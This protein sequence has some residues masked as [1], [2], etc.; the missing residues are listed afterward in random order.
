M[1]CPNC[2][3]RTNNC[4]Y[5]NLFISDETAEWYCKM[6][7]YSLQGC[8]CDKR[9]DRCQR[10]GDHCVCRNIKE[11]TKILEELN[12]RNE[13][14]KLM[15]YKA[16]VLEK[17]ETAIPKGIKHDKGKN[18]LQLIPDEMIEGIGEILTFGATKYEKHNWRKGLPYDKVYG[19]MKRHLSKWH[20]GIVN[21]EETGKPHLWHAGCCLCFLITY[22]A[23]PETYKEFDDRFIYGESNA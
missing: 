10:F 21:D 19:A 18:M 23:H 16:V 8:K 6:C 12:D 4:S 9:C 14:E 22:E 11:K 20:K 17:G 7:R 3:T 5:C 1:I 15:D 13:H 2:Q